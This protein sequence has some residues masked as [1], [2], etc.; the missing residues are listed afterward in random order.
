MIGHFEEA[1]GTADVSNSVRKRWRKPSAFP[2]SN[3]GND[4]VPQNVETAERFDCCLKIAEQ[5]AIGLNYRARAFTKKIEIL[6]RGDAKQFTGKN[7]CRTVKIIQAAHLPREIRL[8]Q[9][10]AAS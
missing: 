1:T 8:R 4:V 2:L 3:R 10:P 6:E 9:N 7:R 5:F